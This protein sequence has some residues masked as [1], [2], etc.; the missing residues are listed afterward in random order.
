MEVIALDGSRAKRIRPKREPELYRL[1]RRKPEILDK[2]TQ[3]RMLYVNRGP[4][5][6]PD[7][8]AVNKQGDLLLGEVKR[9]ALPRGAWFQAKQYAKRFAK[10]PEAAIDAELKKV[11]IHKGIR[12]AMR[13]FLGSTALR[14]LLNPS[15]R[16]IQLVFVA[17]HFADRTL[18]VANRGA[19]GAI[20]RAAVKD[21][22][23]VELRVYRVPR[24]R[25]VA[26]ASVIG[27]RR[28]RLR[29]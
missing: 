26:V 15:R 2:D 11:R 7:F 28:R 24:T 20:L 17:E 10:M 12:R 19:L 14:A 8:L 4:E 6:G 16:K 29:R 21:V 22:K 5:K 9:G 27:G 13:G 25:T 23:C 18:Q 1:L 3:V